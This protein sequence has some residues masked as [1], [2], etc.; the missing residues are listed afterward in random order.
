MITTV[1]KLTHTPTARVAVASDFHLSHE[2][3]F[4]WKARGFASCAAQTERFVAELGSLTAEDVLL[5][6]GDFSLNS[7]AEATAALL[8]R[9][10]A[11]IFYVWGNHESWMQKLYSGALQVGG[12][13]DN[14]EVYPLAWEHV[15]FLGPQAV[16]KIN[17]TPVFLSHFAHRWWPR[18]EDGVWH[19]CGHTHGNDTACLPAAKEGKLLDVSA[20]V[21]LATVGRCFFYF[22]EIA[23]IMAQKEIGAGRHGSPNEIPN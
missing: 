15:T 1:P 20:D 16:V 11:R 13:P 10:R 12:Y 21:A 5:Y 22:E 4:I 18:R 2:R 6:L 9:I 7:S 14:V 17:G 23:T 19:L 3:E 8:Q